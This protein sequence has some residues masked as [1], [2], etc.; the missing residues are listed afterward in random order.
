MD[1][2][3]PPGPLGWSCRVSVRTATLLVTLLSAVA[4][5]QAEMG[6]ERK[7]LVWVTASEV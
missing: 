6:S 4:E 5:Y 3:L 7:G 1:N 2:S